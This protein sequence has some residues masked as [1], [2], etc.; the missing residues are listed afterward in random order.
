MT[1]HKLL[2]HGEE[3][4]IF[5]LFDISPYRIRHQINKNTFVGKIENFEFLLQNFS[6]FIKIIF[7]RTIRSMD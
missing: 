4:N 3:Y 5:H 2:D 1:I 7:L 6:V